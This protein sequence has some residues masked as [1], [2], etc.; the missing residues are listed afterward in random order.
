MSEKSFIDTLRNNASTDDDFDHFL[1]S[2]PYCTDLEYIT[3]LDNNRNSTSILSMNIRSLRA[4][5]NI[6][7]SFIERMKLQN[8][9]PSVIC[10]QETW[11]SEDD[12]VDV[13]KLSGF[14]LLTHGKSASECGGLAMY[15]HNS[16]KF[17]KLESPKFNEIWEGQFI[18]VIGSRDKKI[19]IGNIY[20]PPSTSLEIFSDSFVQFLSKFRRSRELVVAGDYN[21]DLLKIFATGNSKHQQYSEFFDTLCTFA[22]LPRI[23]S[24][25]RIATDRETGKIT[26]E[27]LIDNFYCRLQN[28][29]SETQAGILVNKFS[30]HQPYFIVLNLGIFRTKCPTNHI[31]HR[32]TTK[33]SY[34]NFKHTFTSCNLTAIT[35]SSVCGDPNALYDFLDNALAFSLAT[36]F[37]LVKR[38]F[39]KYLDKQNPWIT[40]E[41]LRIIKRRDR[42]LKKRK[43]AKGKRLGKISDQLKDLNKRLDIEIYREK[44]TYYHNQFGTRRGNSKRTWDLINEILQKGKSGN[45][46]EYFIG[47]DGEK[48][49]GFKDAAE[50]FNKFFSEIGPSLAKEMPS[51]SGDVLDYLKPADTSTEF[52][53]TPVLDID[54][55][56]ALD[57]LKPKLSCGVDG[58]SAKLL[59]FMKTEIT[60]F[61]TIIINRTLQ[62]GIF[63]QKLKIAKV[64]ALHKKDDLSTFSNYRPISL[65]PS[66]SKIFER[67]IHDQITYFFEHNNLF[68]SN[69]F[70]YRKAHSTDFAAIKF[71][72]NIIQK[73]N[74]GSIS[75]AVFMDLSKAFDTIDH[76]IL[77]KKLKFYCFSENAIK[78]IK[79]YLSER[80]QFVNYRGAESSMQKM[81]MG[82]PQGSILGPLLFIIYINDLWKAS[83]SLEPICYADD[84]TCTFYF[85]SGNYSISLINL[86]INSVLSKI[87]NWFL[88][89]KLSLNVSKTNFMIFHKKSTIIPNLNL[90]INN[91]NLKRV[92]HFK[93]L[94]LTISE[95]ITW[96][97]H[98]KN[99]SLKINRGLGIIKTVKSYLPAQ[100]L[101]TLYYSLINCHFNN[102]ILLWGRNSKS[103]YKLQKNSIRLITNS[104]YI[105]HTSPLLK[106]LKILKFPDFYKLAHIKFYYKFFN[107]QLPISLLSLDIRMHSD[108]HPYPTRNSH[109]LTTV[110]DGTFFNSKSLIPPLIVTVNEMDPSIRN[111]IETHSIQNIVERVKTAI[112]DSYPFN[113]SK[114]NCYSC[115]KSSQARNF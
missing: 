89:N 43:K 46:P 83:E 44:R 31:T 104:H 48:I 34:D 97:N 115:L 108:I 60:P 27:T 33:D 91:I 51:G 24:P 68:Y 70:G 28:H 3:I 26:S 42:V 17:T 38:R 92:P 72:E 57:K 25:T 4:K 88:V 99:I 7:S 67:I 55:S 29:L 85:P 105:A 110:S 2:S 6:L 87:N 74:S 5:F 77:L 64:T 73:I 100:T 106:R 56:R 54:V 93:F 49:K 75:V 103:I 102:H 82:V 10:I 12:Y 45:F 53:F 111:K 114:N 41:T 9:C 78:L 30:D 16:I 69:Q 50:G 62:T 14:S 71:I 65:L 63:P 19:I 36:A 23:V 18:E 39:N 13:F 35:N 98:I 96:D 1:A 8:T 90:E 79:N 86:L 40:E 113:C 81:T 21:I 112:L 76:Q 94:G 15:I 101:E 20:K 59:K 80:T 22:I 58:I 84:T 11:L 37:P 47:E 66:I 32:K 52:H 61:L 95:T 109:K 107:K